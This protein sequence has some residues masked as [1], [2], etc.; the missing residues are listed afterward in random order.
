MILLIFCIFRDIYLHCSLILQN[1]M[2]IYISI[3]LFIVAFHEAVCG[4]VLGPQFSVAHRLDDA[5]SLEEKHV[6][7]RRKYPIEYILTLFW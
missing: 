6:D 2:K 3:V 4:I 7:K 5:V 1:T